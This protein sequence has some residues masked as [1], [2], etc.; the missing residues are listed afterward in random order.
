MGATLAKLIDGLERRSTWRNAALAVGGIALSNLAMGG[1][2][3]PNIEARRPEALENGFLVMIDLEPLRSAEE[4]YRI[5]DLYKPD[6]LGLVRLLYA[7]D[8]VIPLTFAVCIL[9]LIGKMLRYLEVK[10]G[11]WRV[12]LLLPFAALPFDYTE[13]ALSLFLISQYQD[14]QVFPTL[15][16]VASITT[17][18]KFLALGCT[19]LTMV[20]LLLRTATKLIAQRAGSPRGA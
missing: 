4:V 17:A 3:L 13:N 1:Y 16:R 14:G 9:C 20:A 7:L 11:G 10:E 6:I 19:G 8:F 12:A 15:A 2:I 18:A 5:F